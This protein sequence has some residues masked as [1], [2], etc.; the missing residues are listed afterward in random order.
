MPEES[1]I[2]DLANR[3]MNLR[4]I[5]FIIK[6]ISHG[7]ITCSIRNI[8]NNIVITVYGDR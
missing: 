1:G 5:N 8:S 7:D 2:G 6:Q 3:C 4:G